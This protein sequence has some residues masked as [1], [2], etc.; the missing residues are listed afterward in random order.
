MNRLSSGDC[1]YHQLQMREHQRVASPLQLYGKLARLRKE[2]SFTVGEI[3]Y[4][5]V[6]ANVYSY[7]RFARNSAPYLIIVNIGT[8]PSTL[9]LTATTGTRYGKVMAYA[10]PVQKGT[11]RR[12]FQDGQ[13]IDLN[14][15]TLKPGEGLVLL[16]LLEIVMDMGPM[17]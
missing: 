5:H 17:T 14:S 12:S 13:T 9:D 8:T 4:S 16:L 7:M 2:V 11:V 1:F 15:V 6:D 3:Q 10:T